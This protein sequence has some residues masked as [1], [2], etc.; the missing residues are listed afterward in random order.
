MKENWQMNV[1]LLLVALGVGYMLGRTSLLPGAEA[2]M[3]SET[4][5]IAVVMG[6]ARED[7]APLCVI[8]TLEQTIMVYKYDYSGRDLDFETVRTYRF[9][10]QLQSY[11]LGDGPSPTEVRRQLERM[12]R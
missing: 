6:E 7:E 1:I 2:Q 4:G 11:N 5:R 12:N 8:D 10:K 9:D 3:G